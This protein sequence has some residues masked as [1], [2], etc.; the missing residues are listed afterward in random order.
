MAFDIRAIF[1]RALGG[2]QYD[3]ASPDGMDADDE[4]DALPESPIEAARRW[5]EADDRHNSRGGATAATA[6]K[7]GGLAAIPTAAVD[8]ASASADDEVDEDQAIEVALVAVAAAAVNGPIST[9]GAEE[10]LEALH[11]VS[12]LESLTATQLGELFQAFP[13]VRGYKDRTAFFDAVEDRLEG[14]AEAVT[15]PA[16]RPSRT[17]RHR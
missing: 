17:G 15:D 4:Q 1:D 6:L 14:I 12:G 5:T 16:L 3:G 13:R 8:E 2:T 10:L 9:E 7:P 11:E